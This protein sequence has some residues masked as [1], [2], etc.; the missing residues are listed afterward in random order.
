MDVNIS[1]PQDNGRRNVD[2]GTSDRRGYGIARTVIGALL[3]IK[4]YRAAG[5][6]KLLQ[7]VKILEPL[8][9]V[10]S[11]VLTGSVYS[12][13]MKVSLVV[14]LL[15]S[16]AVHE[17]GHYFATKKRGL[18][19]YWWL[20]VPFVGALMKAP[21]FRSRDDEAYIA[22]GGPLVGGVFSLLLY[23]A[24][25]V[26]PLPKEWGNI[27]F[28]VA[29]LSTL[30]NLFN[31]I[32]L[33][34]IDGGRITAGVSVWFRVLGFAVLLVLSLYTA[35]ASMLLVW[36][37]ILSE[38]RMHPL[39]RLVIAALMWVLMAALIVMGYH[40]GSVIEDWCY[41]AVGMWLL[42]AFYMRWKTPPAK[43]DYRDTPLSPAQRK[44]WAGLYCG[45]FIALALL[46]AVF[47]F[48][49]EKLAL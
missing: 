47:L 32:P 41:F 30:L 45:L 24:W 12:L 43:N 46:L 13:T 25:L 1:E 5:A 2:R 15:V 38:I 8:L 17:L 23:G 19:A 48:Q 3:F 18:H 42:Y 16:L 34:P 4:L 20:F 28:T 14:G 9:M 6:L 26:L 39:M 27:L 49:G 29:F 31:M 40:G 21:D 35:Q 44:K 37:L 33:P 7:G 11:G 10:A 22:F 36:I